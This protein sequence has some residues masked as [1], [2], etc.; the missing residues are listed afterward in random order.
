LLLAA[1]DAFGRLFLEIFV[2]FA[3]FSLRLVQQRLILNNINMR[4][5]RTRARPAIPM[6]TFEP[7]SLSVAMPSAISSFKPPPPP[8]L[9]PSSTAFTAE[10]DAA[11]ALR[12]SICMPDVEFL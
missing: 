1:L 2:G 8:P 10:A 6:A 5:A 12:V 4:T 11:P 7:N 3:E 9:S